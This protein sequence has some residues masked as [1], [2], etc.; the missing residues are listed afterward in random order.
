MLSSGVAPVTLGVWASSWWRREAATTQKAPTG[1][2]QPHNTNNIT[3][4]QHTKTQHHQQHTT[5]QPDHHT[6][7]HPPSQQRRSAHH[8]APPSLSPVLSLDS[9]P[10]CLLP[11]SVLSVLPRFCSN[12][13]LSVRVLMYVCSSVCLSLSCHRYIEKFVV[14]DYKCLVPLKMVKAYLLQ[15]YR[16]K[17]SASGT[18]FV[19]CVPVD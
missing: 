10:F 8:T 15:F 17:S 5:T 13:R 14:S 16:K 11:F 19:C 3:H 4:Q 7:T 9:F 6:T 1:E 2:T 12:V 18:P